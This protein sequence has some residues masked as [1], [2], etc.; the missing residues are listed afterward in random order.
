MTRA[1]VRIMVGVVALAVI[2]VGLFLLRAA[3]ANGAGK[4]FSHWIPNRMGG[5]RSKWKATM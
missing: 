4:E 1:V 2:G 5:P 3:G